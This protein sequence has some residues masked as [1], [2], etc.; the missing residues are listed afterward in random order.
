MKKNLSKILL[1][2]ALSGMLFSCSE[3]FLDQPAIGSYKTEDMAN[4]AAVEKLLVGAYASLNGQSGLVTVPTLNLMG[5]IHGTEAF[6]GS[7]AGDQPAM[8]EFNKFDVGTGNGS[9]EGFW[10]FYYDAINRCNLVLKNLALAD[11]ISAARATQIAAE[12]RFLRAHYYFFL[13]IN[14]QNIPWIDETTV[15]VRQPNTTD[16]WPNITADMQYAADNLPELQAQVG[17]PNNWAAKA[18]LGKILVYQ[19]RY[20]E[21]LPI[22]NDVMLNGKTAKGDAYGLEANYHD[23]FNVLKENGKEAVFSIQHSA[24]DGT[25]DSNPVNGDNQ[26]Q[27]TMSQNKQGPGLGSG[28]GFFQPTPYSVD[29]FRTSVDGLP[30]LDMY[31]TNTHRIADDY[32]LKMTDPFTVDDHPVDPRLDIAVGRRGV[33]FLDYGMFSSAWIRDQGHGGPYLMKK[34]NILKS[35]IGTYSTSGRPRQALNFILIRYADVLLLAAECEAQVG[36][37]DNARTLVNQVRNRIATGTDAWVMNEAGDG[38]A[39]N[40]VVAPYPEDGSANDPF[41]SKESAL[42]AILMER[43]LEL[44]LEGHRFY[45]VIRF[46]MD[47]EIFNE[48]LE[49]EVDRFDYLDLSEY[50]PVPDKL[51]PIPRVAI[52]RSLVGSEFTLQQNPGY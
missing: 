3:S 17:R 32:G 20:T 51:L 7:N 43:T 40:Y 10:S 21:A 30:Y 1:T 5:S 8:M 34:Y 25:A 31:E 13:K 16:V 18:Y 42:K 9:V 29:H 22:F 27:W 52:D 33:P 39:A 48:F 46:G 12:V 14:F 28:W 50:T 37:L 6:K 19:G 23:N 36:S 15:D 24:N 44:N 2:L 41:T 4:S 45:D 49:V 38:Y 35:Q 26:H 11:D 47:E